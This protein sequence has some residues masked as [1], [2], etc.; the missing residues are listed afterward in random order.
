MSVRRFRLVTQGGLALAVLGLGAIVSSAMAQDVPVPPGVQ[1]PLLL[2]ILTFDRNL[3]DA[4]EP[5]VVGVV[6]QRRNRASAAVGDE[7]RLLLAASARPIRVV[8]I[9]LDET[10]DLRG[11]LLRESVRVVYV[12][13]LQA[14]SVST[15]AEATRGEGVVSVT[16]V[17]RYVEQG[18]AVGIDLSDSR[19]R[20]VINLAASRAE[21]ADFSAELLKL[22]RLAGPKALTP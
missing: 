7:V 8:V 11:T 21:G 18:L 1:V 17:P 3:A 22:A 5:L 20:I 13:P 19:P 15:V 9:D 2:K 14:V 4:P 6:F 12:G 16:G 10:H